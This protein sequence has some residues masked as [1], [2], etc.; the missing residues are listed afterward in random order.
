MPTWQHKGGEYEDEKTIRVPK[1][2]PGA[3]AIPVKLQHPIAVAATKENM[4]SG[5][6]QKEREGQAGHKQKRSK[7]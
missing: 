7:I 2:S 6:F 1:T 5:L 4:N 3:V